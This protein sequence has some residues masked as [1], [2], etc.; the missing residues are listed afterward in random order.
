MKWG[1]LTLVFLLVCAC[2]TNESCRAAKE[3]GTRGRC[4]ADYGSCVA[5]SDAD[6]KRSTLCLEHG[7]CTLRDGECQN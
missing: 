5:T 3:C 7:R 2:K 6:C 4:T 1:W